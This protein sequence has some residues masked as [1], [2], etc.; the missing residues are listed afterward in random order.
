MAFILLTTKDGK[1][2]GV[3]F[4]E[5]RVNVLNNRGVQ[6]KRFLKGLKMKESLIVGWLC[7]NT[8]HRFVRF[9]VFLPAVDFILKV[10]T[11][12]LKEYIK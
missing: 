10:V 12:E 8:L 6:F 3:D 7:I 5:F 11:C 1:N 9:Q 4:V 2:F